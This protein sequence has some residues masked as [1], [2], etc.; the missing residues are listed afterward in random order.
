MSMRAR[1]ILPRR[2]GAVEFEE[3]P[4]GLSASARRRTALEAEAAI[5]RRAVSR[6]LERPADEAIL[7]GRSTVMASGG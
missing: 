5:R 1:R 2:C 6:Y 4:P 3:G 7:V